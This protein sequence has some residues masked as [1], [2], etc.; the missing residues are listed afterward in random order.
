MRR[1]IPWLTLVALL[2]A[3]ENATDPLGGI[4]NGGGGAITPAQAT[5]N[6]SFTVKKTTTLPCS[7]AP[8]ADGQVITA[9]LDVLS[10]GTLSTTT[11]T[12]RNPISGA[13]DP[14]S[15]AVGLADGITS[16]TFAAP[17]VSS[18]A[19]MELR[20]T[21]TSAGAFT[22]GRLTDPA[23]GFSQVFGTGGC[24]YTATGVRTG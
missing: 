12:W 13:V 5:G 8:L 24:E 18:T 3:C 21:L 16:L 23:P 2:A 20:G 7:S 19:G 6:W 4:L 10:D 17:D 1:T 9:H 11:S 14:L 15:G 22:G